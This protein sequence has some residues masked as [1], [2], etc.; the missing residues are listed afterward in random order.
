MAQN[1][2]YNEV[3]NKKKI[4]ANIR[5]NFEKW[6]KINMPNANPARMCMYQAVFT[7][8]YLKSMGSLGRVL[9]SAGSHAFPRIDL[10]D[11][12]GVVHTHFSYIFDP[13]KVSEAIKTNTLP[14]VHV[15]VQL[16]DRGEIVDITTRYLK[17]QCETL[18][19]LKWL[20]PDPPDFLWLSP[21]DLPEGVAYE[22]DMNACMLIE[23]FC[24]LTWG[25]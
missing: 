21:N 25:F 15:W 13:N 4:V 18:S 10:K 2:C 14:E 8:S 22:P 19:G 9:I 5:Q 1:F 20:A 6:R 3:M 12:D 17:E 11:D 7:H 23:H 24:K 16:P